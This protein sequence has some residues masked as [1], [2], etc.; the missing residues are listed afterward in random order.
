VGSAE[1]AAQE[2][3]AMPGAAAAALCC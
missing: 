2:S 1:V 3:R